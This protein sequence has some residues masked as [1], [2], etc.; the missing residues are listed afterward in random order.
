MTAQRDDHPG[1]PGS[2]TYSGDPVEAAKRSARARARSARDGLDRRACKEA[3]ADAS[4]NI[5]KLPDLAAVG[6]VLAYAALPAEIDPLSAV[7]VLRRRGAKIAYP[8]IESPGVL[9]V[10]VVDHELD[11]VAGPFGLAQPRAEAPL[12]ALYRIDVALV[13]GVAFDACGARLGYG[14][15]YY[16]RLL[17]HLRPD[18]LKIGV[19]F[20][21]QILEEIP[22]EEHDENVD[23]IVTQ[24]RIIRPSDHRLC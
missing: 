20:D 5:L 18:C 23:V 12:A 7:S 10:H 16:D 3:S 17:P 19:A 6:L 8:R 14:G 24:T 21:E 2:A 15:G 11:L 22:A 1:A 9:C 4:L 13:P